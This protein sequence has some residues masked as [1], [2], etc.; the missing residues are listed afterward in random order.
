[1]FLLREQRVRGN[2][3]GRCWRVNGGVI[4][5]RGATAGAQRRPAHCSTQLSNYAER[6]A[7]GL[8]GAGNWTVLFSEVCRLAE[9]EKLLP[10]EPRVRIN[11]ILL[12]THLPSNCNLKKFSPIITSCI[13]QLTI[14]C[15]PVIIIYKFTHNN[16]SLYT[17]EESNE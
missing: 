7:V 16:H 11:G 1:M 15:P 12:R 9:A 4:F 6:S 3:T 13:Y 10:R 5:L 8:P 17:Q 2:C 14:V